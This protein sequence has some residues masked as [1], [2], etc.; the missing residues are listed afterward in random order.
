MFPQ[1]SKGA[2]ALREACTAEPA[3]ETAN[4]PW[5]GLTQNHLAAQLVLTFA[6]RL[7]FNKRTQHTLRKAKTHEDKWWMPISAGTC[8]C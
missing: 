7:R 3:Y 6:Q 5:N 1:V 4:D 8:T 2:A